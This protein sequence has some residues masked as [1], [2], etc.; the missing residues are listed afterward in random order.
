MN[1]VLVTALAPS[2]GACLCKGYNANGALIPS[3]E[4]W[5]DGLGCKN[6]VEDDECDIENLILGGIPPIAKMLPDVTCEE[7]EQRGSV[8]AFSAPAPIPAP[9]PSPAPTP[10]PTH[11]EMC[12]TWAAG[13]ECIKNPHYMLSRCNR[14]C[15]EHTAQNAQKDAKA[16]KDAKGAKGA[17]GMKG[18]KA[19]KAKK[20]TNK[21]AWPLNSTDNLKKIQAVH[22]AAPGV[23]LASA[24]VAGRFIVMLTRVQIA[25]AAS[26]P[27]CKQSWKVNEERMH[28]VV[29]ALE[30][31]KGEAGEGGEFCGEV[32]SQLKFLN[33]MVCN[34]GPSCT[35]W[36]AQ[37]PAIENIE[38]DM[39]VGIASGAGVGTFST[40]AEDGTAGWVA[41]VADVAV[42]TVAT[43]P[44]ARRLRGKKAKVGHA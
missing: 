14:S 18:A 32:V 28:A 27:G 29:E 37:L 5:S 10:K 36:M 42:P 34:L 6:V 26:N 25:C 12:A 15:E 41:D 31:H 30:K 16:K 23:L 13:G 17:K 43:T 8:P 3:T 2:H 20:T 22:A 11:N 38:P 9:T 1:S 40:Q 44:L 24:P 21:Y 39:E 33:M 4:C 19:K 7:F 35:K